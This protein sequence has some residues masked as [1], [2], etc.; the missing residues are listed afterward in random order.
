[1]RAFLTA[2]L[3]G[4][5]MLAAPTTAHA[6]ALSA[7]EAAELR[8]EL[9]AL[10]AKVDT[11]EARLDGAIASP[12]PAPAPVAP[13]PTVTAKPATEIGWKGAPELKT[14]DGWSFKPRGRILVDAGHVSAPSAIS[15]RALGFSN[16]LR[17]VRLGV[18]G[19]IPGGFGYKLEA[20][21]AGGDAELTDAHLTYKDGPLKVTVGQHNNFQG[22]EEL[23]SSNDTSFIERAAFTDAFG[24]ERRVGVSGE[25]ATGDVIVQGGVFT[26]NFGDLS[27]SGNSSVSLDG[28]LVFAPKLGD[29]QLHFGAS[30]HWRDLGD[31]V[32]SVRYRQRPL[33]HTA[34]IRFISTPSIGA[35]S[36]TGYGAEAA[37]IS[38][39]FHGAA[40]AFWQ[41]V[42]RTGAADPTFFGGAVEA[43]V[44][45]TDDT[46]GY[47]SGVF[48][49][50][51]VKNPVGSGGLGAW[52]LNLRYDHLDLND[53]G[54]DGGKQHGY[55]ASLIWTPIDYVR[56]MVNYARLEYRDA[57]IAAGTDRDYGVDT[58]G[59]RAQIV[60]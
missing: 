10:K 7:E 57:V 49:G 56:F 5:T 16:E 48:R 19:T 20:D 6:Q 58:F 41:K 4:T 43:G 29:T 12:V 38:G 3:L 53:A 52:Q 46:R 35:K 39:R 37:F 23:S 40:E 34:D 31:T 55:M 24:F 26:D 28:R 47:R 44:F 32:T 9:A 18:E 27:D 42:G 51:K 8:A 59:M 22:L 33:V 2:A 45:L 13:A 14:A 36:E 50:V 60:F 25:V 54:I 17:R 11:L 30:A 21:F 1:M 15:D